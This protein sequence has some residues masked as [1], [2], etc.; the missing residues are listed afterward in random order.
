MGGK[1]F[2]KNRVKRFAKSES[3]RLR[4]SAPF[5]DLVAPGAGKVSTQLADAYD[6]IG[7]TSKKKKAKPKAKSKSKSKP[8][9]KRRPRNFDY[10]HDI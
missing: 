10:E 9:P 1:K 7:G 3:K 5:I 2:L 4:S 6:K 8:K